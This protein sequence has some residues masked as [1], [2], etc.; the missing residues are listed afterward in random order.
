MGH[1]KY[2]YGR[3]YDPKEVWPLVAGDF[4]TAVVTKTGV[5][6]PVALDAAADVKGVRRSKR[7]T[8]NVHSTNNV[9]KEKK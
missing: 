4:L 8:I 5:L 1:G 6:R 9:I 3:C 7:K 2:S